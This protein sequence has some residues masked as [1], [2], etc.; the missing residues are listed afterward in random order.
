MAD[1]DGSNPD[2]VASTKRGDADTRNASP[3]NVDAKNAS[4]KNADVKSADARIE[5][6]LRGAEFDE[7][8]ADA[9]QDSCA[10]THRRNDRESDS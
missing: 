2:D 8:F 4:A 10:V 5:H 9:E 7:D 1:F 6:H 3:K